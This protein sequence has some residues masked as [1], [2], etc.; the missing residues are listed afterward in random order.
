MRQTTVAHSPGACRGASAVSSQYLR[1]EGVRCGPQTQPIVG[2]RNVAVAPRVAQA[3]THYGTGHASQS[4]SA[5]VTAT[6]RIVP[7]HV[8]KRRLN[9]TNFVVPQGYK[10][11]W[12]DDRLNPKRAE[13]T[14]GGRADMLLVWTQT[15]PRRLINQNNGRDMTA[16]VPL[17]YP[18]TSVAQQRRDLGEVTLVQ[19]DGQLVKRILRNPGVR[20]VARQPV[21]STRSAPQVT[22]PET[23]APSKALGG[24]RYVQVGT[25][26]NPVNAQRAARNI[27]RMGMPARIGKRKQGGQT[28]LRVQAGPFKGTRAMQSAMNRLRGAGYRDAIAR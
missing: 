13:Q 10:P 23:V 14:L 25:F 15:L 7:K 22:A 28:Y 5:Q 12:E 20:P 8:A 21:Y 9:T 2:V 26:R 27:A 1:G 18:Y 11:V 19:R 3:R 24:K 17:I 6:T 16:S 4:H